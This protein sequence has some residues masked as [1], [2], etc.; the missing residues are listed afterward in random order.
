MENFINSASN[1]PVID[2]VAQIK[3][4]L[5]ATHQVISPTNRLLLPDFKTVIRN[6]LDGSDAL[7]NTEIN[8]FLASTALLHCLDGWAY[9][10]HAIDSLITGDSRIAIHLGYYSE[11]RASMSFLS[12]EGI[13]IFNN[14]YISA[15]A[16]N[17]IQ[18]NPT[19]DRVTTTS[20]NPSTHQFIWNS[21]DTWINSIVKPTNPSDLLGV[22]SVDGKNFNEWLT[23]FPYTSPNSG[24]LVL[25]NWLSSWNFDIN[26]F[27]KDREVRN[28][29]SYQTP[30]LNVSQN[31]YTLNQNI[32]KLNSFWDILEPSGKNRF[33]LL[34][35]YL[36]RELLR[37]IYDQQTNSVKAANTF[38]S[39]VRKTIANMGLTVQ[40]S[41][42]NFMISHDE[43]ELFVE[44][45]NTSI[46]P[47]TNSLNPLSVIARA[48]LMLRISTG[49]VSHIL[50]RGGMTKEDLDFLWDKYGMENGFWTT[51]DLPEDFISL[52][53]DIKDE[54]E[55]V[56]TWANTKKPDL[57][58]HTMYSDANVP[59]SL[60]FFKQF[61]RAGLW[62]MSL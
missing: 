31:I 2:G 39:L 24:I 6:H 35:K 32:D 60:N 41:F 49:S 10:S 14:G 37:I 58:L 28:V 7:S 20:I 29:V 21:L 17:S 45:F 15:D 11:L 51:G 13:G 59:Y 18:R 50:N 5:V 8:T 26:H 38:E 33:Q 9:L 46:D 12:S 25:K 52:W 34:D 16:T 42:I 56:T 48:T 36:L 22:F 30:N 47:A 3:N 1:I 27:K 54:V 57:D 44:S 23:H 43:H 55:Q 4:T 53:E 19:R 61:H 40:Q 62:G